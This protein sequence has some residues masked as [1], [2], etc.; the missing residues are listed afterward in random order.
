MRTHVLRVPE[1]STG[2]ERVIA[3]AIATHVVTEAIAKRRGITIEEFLYD[4]PDTKFGK[5]D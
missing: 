2:F 5:G 4:Q 1:G 3:E